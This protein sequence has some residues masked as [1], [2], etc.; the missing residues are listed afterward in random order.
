MPS[1]DLQTRRLAASWPRSRSSGSNSDPQPGKGSELACSALPNY[2][3]AERMARQV[4][5]AGCG[6]V[7]GASS[8][9]WRPRSLDMRGCG[10]SQHCPGGVVPPD[11]SLI[12]GLRR[13][14]P[15]NGSGRL[16][17]ARSLPPSPFF[18][19]PSLLFLPFIQPHGKTSKGWSEHWARSLQ[20]A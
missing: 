5:P 18:S 15:E 12:S 3:P 6:D 20:E 11:A 9:S 14:P 7:R 4:S 2:R 16:A 8:T 17:A 19:L 1:W 10:G 13:T